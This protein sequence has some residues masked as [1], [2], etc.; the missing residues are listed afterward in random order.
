MEAT[1]VYGPGLYS[2][3]FGSRAASSEA[4]TYFGWVETSRSAPAGAKEPSEIR[5]LSLIHISEP[6]RPY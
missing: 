3:V 5:Y 4:L 1:A 2:I 6:T